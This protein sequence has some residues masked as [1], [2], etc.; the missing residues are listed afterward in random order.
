MT[1]E[2]KAK[3]YDEAFAKIRDKYECA[4]RDG[5]L[6]WCIYEEIFP[7][8]AES[9]DE[10]IRKAIL[11]CIENAPSDCCM[12]VSRMEMRTWI[13]KQKEQQQR[14]HLSQYRHS[15]DRRRFQPQDIRSEV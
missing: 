15:A 7:E 11:N 12:E 5:N 8:L 10:R 4:K 13:V 1:L 9:E 6:I 14:Q 2:E 3:A